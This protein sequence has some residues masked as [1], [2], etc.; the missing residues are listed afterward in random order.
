MTRIL[1]C[2]IC[3]PDL[4]LFPERDVVVSIDGRF[5]WRRRRPLLLRD[6]RVLPCLDVP[7]QL[8]S[9]WPR[10]REQPPPR[11]QSANELVLESVSSKALSLPKKV[12][13]ASDIQDPFAV[14]TH[15]LGVFQNNTTHCSK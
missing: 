15:F 10:V 14:Y 9:L 8:Q 11:D 6:I 3:R 1:V 13:A 5:L 4:V 12:A 7:L 2:R